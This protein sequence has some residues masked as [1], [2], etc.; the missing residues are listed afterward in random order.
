MKKRAIV[1]VFLGICL[2]GAFAAFA[3]PP[4]A[5]VLDQPATCI[6]AP[7]PVLLAAADQL[8]LPVTYIV[9]VPTR[10]SPSILAV[11]RP[12]GSGKQIGGDRK[13]VALVSLRSGLALGHEKGFAVQPVTAASDK[14]AQSDVLVASLIRP[15]PG[16][17]QSA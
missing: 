13:A 14:G 2:L 9:M 11:S 17:E 12:D 3:Q 5:L 6:T 15:L 7:A 10:A 16:S 8:C 1:A 4:P